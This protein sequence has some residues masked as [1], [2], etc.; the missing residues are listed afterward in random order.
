MTPTAEFPDDSAFPHSTATAPHRYLQR[1]YAEALDTTPD[2]GTKESL[3][4]GPLPFDYAYQHSPF[5][6]VTHN[7]QP[8]IPMQFTVANLGDAVNIQAHFT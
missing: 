3:F 6:F 5:K 8:P 1:F 4:I 7:R 2:V